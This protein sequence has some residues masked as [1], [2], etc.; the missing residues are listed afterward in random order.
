MANRFFKVQIGNQIFFRATASGR[1]YLSAW[2]DRGIWIS[3]SSKAPGLGASP[4]VEIEKAEFNALVA[5]KAARVIAAGG[6]NKYE[7]KPSDSWV[8]ADALAADP[9]EDFNYVGSRHH[10]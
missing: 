3:Y 8:A 6:N 7:N 1:T 4:V 2:L 9:L 10:Y 5:A